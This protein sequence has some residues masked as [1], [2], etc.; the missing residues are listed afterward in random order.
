MFPGR[1]LRAASVLAQAENRIRLLDRVVPLNLSSELERLRR[2]R[3]AELTLEPSFTY[4]PFAEARELRAGLDWLATEL[5]S[6]D[7]QD[8]LFSARAAELALEA[9]LVEALGTPAFA[10]LAR[11]RFPGAASAELGPL[12]ALLAAFE[13]AVREEPESPR[14]AADSSD[15]RSLVRVLERRLRESGVSARVELRPE[16]GSVAAAGDGVIYVRPSARLSATEAERVALHELEGHVLP[17]QRAR[18]EPNPIFSVGTRAASEDEEGRALLLEERAGLQGWERK[19]EL[20]LRHRAAA[21][22]RA[23]AS[24]SEGV[25]ALEDAGVDTERALDLAL[26]AHRGGGLAREIVY[27]PAF[28]RV[29]RALLRE[30]ELEGWLERGRISLAAARTLSNLQGSVSINTGA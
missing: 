4:A 2:A 7:P 23:G 30:P 10:G 12:E 15:P 11:E 25:T 6:G 5:D 18:R 28:V 3:R 19:Q 14:L 27:L 24:F 16:L 17:R 21:L 26:R 20:L 22:V 13:G 8:G 1:L 9:A 29:K